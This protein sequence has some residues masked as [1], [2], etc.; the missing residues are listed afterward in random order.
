MQARRRKLHF[1]PTYKKNICA[2]SRKDFHDYAIGASNENFVIVLDS[3]IF[4]EI[5]QIFHQLFELLYAFTEF[6]S[7]GDAK[8]QPLPT[9]IFFFFMLLHN[10]HDIRFFFVHL[11]PYRK[12][13]TAKFPQEKKP[14]K[15]HK[16]FNWNFKANLR[17]FRTSRGGV[18]THTHTS[19]RDTRRY[20]IETS[21]HDRRTRTELR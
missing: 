1:F 18:R 13:H 17:E 4:W 15:F 8:T 19:H 11:Q 2:M 14:R 20:W 6:N 9:T 16:K 21:K 12:W 10:F 7:R 5:F 3:N